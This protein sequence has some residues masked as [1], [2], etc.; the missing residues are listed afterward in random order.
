M[1]SVTISSVF[2]RGRLKT[3]QVSCVYYLPLFSDY[4]IC[5]KILGRDL[6]ITAWSDGNGLKQDLDV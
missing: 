1:V 3:S 6:R 4:F 2:L 5:W